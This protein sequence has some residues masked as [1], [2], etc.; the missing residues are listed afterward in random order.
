MVGGGNAFWYD[1]AGLT[2]NI[3]T[4]NSLV[5]PAP[6]ATTTYYV[7]FEGTCDT[8]AAVSTEV[9]ILPASIPPASVSSDRDSICPG[10]GILT[11][12]Y[13]GGSLGQGA[14]AEWYSDSLCTIH[15]G[16]GND[17]TVNAPD[18]SLTY[19]VRFEG[20]CD[21]TVALSLSLTIKYPSVAP[22][23]ASISR[24]TIC[25]GDGTLIL[26]YTGGSLGLGAIAVWYD[27][28]GFSNAIGTGNNL[29]IPAPSSATSYYVRFEDEC[30]T[31]IVASTSVHVAQLAAPTFIE[32]DTIVCLNGPLYRYVVQGNPGSAFDWTI[33]GGNIE[34]NF[35]DT[36]L[37]NWGNVPGNYNLGVTEISAQGCV[38]DLLLFGIEVNGPTVDLG[39]DMDICAGA[40][41]T[42]TPSGSYFMHMWHDG[43]TDPTYSADT[44]EKV[45]IQVF[46]EAGCTAIDSVMV[47]AYALPVVDLGN[48]TTVC[49]PLA[50]ILD[51]GN[52]GATYQWSTGETTRQ[53]EA[54]GNQR[55]IW[56]LV[57]FGSD[58]IS[59]DT[60]NITQCS[61]QDYFANIPNLFTPNGDGKNDTWLFYESAAFPEMVIEIFDRWGRL[62][63]ISEPGYPEPWDGRSMNGSELPMDSYHFIMK[64]NDGFE[65]IVG[66]VT[67]VR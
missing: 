47:T 64:L 8:T 3:G 67:I 38:S 7:R 4:G 10:D 56:V 48:D 6:V 15:I 26:S 25:P 35:G 32:P 58:C 13:T 52:P 27:N 45:S 1:D 24:D 55:S 5:I 42:I 43:S 33:S 63:Y 61:V 40:P 30:D 50:F 18:T 14:T 65:E 44:T 66:T 51:A 9:N 53:I 59:G 11:L 37:V 54:T 57:T 34:S 19:W 49:G 2:S 21:T 28:T 17:I 20:D 60:L 39:E 12:S 23:S 16:T 31:T 36:I 22:V 46:D 62:V 41:E 29:E